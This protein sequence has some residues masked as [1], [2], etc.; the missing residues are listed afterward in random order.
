MLLTR[1]PNI[2]NTYAVGLCS[3]PAGSVFA[4]S[5]TAARRAEMGSWREPPVLRA[6]SSSAL[7]NIVRFNRSTSAYKSASN[8]PARHPVSSAATI[9]PERR[10]LAPP[11]DNA[12]ALA[13]R[14]V[15]NLLR[16]LETARASLAAAQRQD[17]GTRQE[18]RRRRQ[19]NPAALP[20]DKR[21][22]IEGQLAVLKIMSARAARE[23][24]RLQVEESGIV[25][26]LASEQGR[27]TDI[28]QRM[29]EFERT[30]TRK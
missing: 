4:I 27:W 9:I 26:E 12:P 20:E 1:C 25:Q 5:R 17:E 14:A 8:S 30:L 3:R 6:P 10:I 7:T 19:L 16:R 24:Q 22:Q 21:G 2:P 15:N 28:N 29:E 11:R 13:R 18:R 23:V